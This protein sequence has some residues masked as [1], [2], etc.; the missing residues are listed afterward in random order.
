[1]TLEIHGEEQTSKMSKVWPD[2]GY[3]V[4]TYGRS[5]EEEHENANVEG[6]L[7]PFPVVSAKQPA[8]F[9]YWLGPRPHGQMH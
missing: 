7:E 9:L 6:H 4:V 2:C 5:V 3:R 8:R 1:M